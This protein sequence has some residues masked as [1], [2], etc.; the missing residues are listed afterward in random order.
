MVA[1][2]S[3]ARIRAHLERFGLT[4]TATSDWRGLRL[5]A[6]SPTAER[7]YVVLLTSGLSALELSA[8]R[9]RVELCLLVSAADL[10]LKW[11]MRM[12]DEVV[13]VVRQGEQLGPGHTI[14][15]DPPVP[16]DDTAFVGAM[17]LSP[18]WL[19]RDFHQVTGEPPVQILQLVPITATELAHKQ[20]FGADAVRERFA[21]LEPD[22]LGP[23]DPSRDCTIAPRGLL[24]A[25]PARRAYPGGARIIVPIEL[26]RTRAAIDGLVCRAVGVT[27]TGTAYLQI[28]TSPKSGVHVLEVLGRPVG[29][30][31]AAMSLVERR[32]VAIRIHDDLGCAIAC[33]DGAQIA[34][35]DGTADAARDLATR[36]LDVGPTAPEPPSV[37]LLRWEG[38]A[39]ASAEGANVVW[40]EELD[41]AFE[42]RV[43]RARLAAV[44][45]GLLARFG[46]W[47]RA[48][49]IYLQTR[50]SEARQDAQVA[51]LD[52]LAFV[53][54]AL[55]EGA[56]RGHEAARQVLLHHG[57]RPQLADELAKFS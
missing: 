45:S 24:P 57:V 22:V 25:L 7:N 12:L 19:G 40:S 2:A 20:R 11:P 32:T 34:A 9:H 6:T 8:E 15:S 53:R 26:A 27:G 56:T 10:D 47:R 43:T 13:S 29:A 5:H 35:I 44:G 31:A 30:L 33:A 36:H 17:V 16:Y 55:P 41:P 3:H 54:A 46:R 51:H 52:V 1:P 42:L 18:A 38:D 48:R 28:T 23:I 14:S 37:R 21:A 4:P 50:T 49:S 39:L